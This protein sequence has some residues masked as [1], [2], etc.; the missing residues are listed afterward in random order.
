MELDEYLAQQRRTKKR[1]KHEES[2]EQIHFVTY[3]RAKMPKLPIF[4]SPMMKFHGTAWQRTKQGARMKRMGYTPGT[5]DLF[6]PLRRKC[7]SGLV[8]EFKTE[9]GTV[10]SDQTEVMAWCSKEGF[11]C[12]VVRSCAEAVKVFDWYIFQP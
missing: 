11:Y 8:L 9:V 5:P 4:M 1:L 3:V 7:Y 10:S 6:L 2:D 12:A